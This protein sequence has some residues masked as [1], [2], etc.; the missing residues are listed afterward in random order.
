MQDSTEEIGGEKNYECINANPQIISNKS[1]LVVIET[2]P[3]HS[4]R[5][6]GW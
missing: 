3:T 5:K 1:L 6:E 4:R 2:I